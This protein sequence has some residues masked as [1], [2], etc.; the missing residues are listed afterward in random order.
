MYTHHA[1]HDGRQV[2]RL[3]HAVQLPLRFLTSLLAFDVRQQVEDTDFAD[4]T[5]HFQ[6]VTKAEPNSQRALF[7]SVC[8]S[9]FSVLPPSSPGMLPFHTRMRCRLYPYPTSMLAVLSSLSSTNVAAVTLTSLR[10]M[11]SGSW[12]V[13]KSRRRQAVAQQDVPASCRP[14]NHGAFSQHASRP[15]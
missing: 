8:T 15:R 14:W 6:E 1:W 13:F 10:T 4:S 2:L 3:L 9:P 5:C 7:C 11:H 12:N